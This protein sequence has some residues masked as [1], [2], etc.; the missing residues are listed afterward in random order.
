MIAFVAWTPLHVINIIN[1]KTTYFPE[2]QSDLYIYG[3]FSGALEIYENIKQQRLFTNVFYIDLEKTGNKFTKI[4]NLIVNKNIFVEYTATYEKLFIQGENYFSKILYGQSKKENPDLELNYIEDGLGAYV[5]SEI[6][7]LKNKKNK[8]IDFFNPYSIFKGK[9]LNYYVY[10]PALVEKKS[11]ANYYPLNKLTEANKATKVIRDIFNLEDE[12]ASF[13]GRVLFL[14]QP[15]EDD[16]FAINEQ[17]LFKQLT[18]LVG[19]ENI[20]IK[21]HPRS[22]R[23][24]YDGFQIIETTLPWE[25]YFLNYD[26]THTV[27]ISTVSTAAFTPKLMMNIDSSI[28]L[29]PK[30]I[31]HQQLK[32]VEDERT[33]I[34]LNNII[35][36]SEEFNVSNSNTIFLPKT[37]KEL[38]VLVQS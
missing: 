1:T 15:L 30:L 18:E 23:K 35:R 21:L 28:I 7:N 12:I 10:E 2:A 29:L 33:Q 16:G 6:L 19:N 34:I 26:F 20:W 27:I 38:K 36:F 11:Q 37:I 17:Q 22:N 31:Q 25:L 32:A 3:E 9:L 5:G 14:D 8:I 4:T 13:P 24:K